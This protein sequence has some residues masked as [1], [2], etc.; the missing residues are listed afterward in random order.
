MWRDEARL[1]DML[2]AAKEV[3]RYTEGVTS[4][5]FQRNRM[6]Q[7]A[8]IRLIE[9]VGEA[10]RNISAD[11]KTAHPEIPWTG[12]IS[13]RNRLAHEY[14][15]VTVDK[16]WEVVNKDVP[17]LVGL[18]EPLVPPDEPNAAREEGGAE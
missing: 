8:V 15:R 13:M 2:L 3:G 18:V 17:A 1:L 16:V 11:F 7:H 14:F 10:A 5:E 9:I 4:E 12:I 6:L